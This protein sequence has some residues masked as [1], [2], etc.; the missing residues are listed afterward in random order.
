[1]GFVRQFVLCLLLAPL[2]A[3]AQSSDQQEL[4]IPSHAVVAAWVKQSFPAIAFSNAVPSNLYLG[5]VI[6]EQLQVLQHSAI[7]RPGLRPISEDIALMFPS[8]STARS[9]MAGVAEF[10]LASGQR[11]GVIW[12]VVPSKSNI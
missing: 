2:G 1:M 3:V 9:P 8:V 6:N 12:V 7:L 10:P 5:Y 11:V 4:A